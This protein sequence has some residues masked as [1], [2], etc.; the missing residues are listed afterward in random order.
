M[1]F[2]VYEC[3][4]L[5]GFVFIEQVPWPSTVPAMLRRYGLPFPA[6]NSELVTLPLSSLVN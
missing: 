3:F 6:D 5:W 4:N 2:V 1:A